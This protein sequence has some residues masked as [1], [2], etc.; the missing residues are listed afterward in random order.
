MPSVVNSMSCVDN[1]T[2][3]AATGGT[4]CQTI[5][6][7]T[8]PSAHDA[9][10]RRMAFWFVAAILALAI[11][12]TTAPS[13]LYRR[14]QAEWHFSSGVLTAVFGVYS[15]AVI[16]SLLLTGSASDGRG[17]KPFILLSVALCVG[18]MV[19]FAVATGVGWLFA[20]RVVQ[21]VGV[22]VGISALGGMLLDLRPGGR[23]SPFV[24]QAAPNIGIVVGA[25]GTGL[26]VD[27]GPKPSVAVYVVL[28][29]AFVALLPVVLAMPETVLVCARKQTA[30]SKIS[31]PAGRKKEFW[32]IALGAISTWAVGG[33]Y[34]SLGPTVSADVLHSSRFVVN[35]LAVALLGA[36]G[37]L[38]ETVFYG[39]SYKS[40]MVIGTVLLGMGVGLVIWSLWPRSAGLFFT[41]SVLLGMGWGLT[42][43]GSFRSLV[44]LAH[45]ARRAEVV[46][47][48][49][50][51]SYLAFS[52]PS[53]AAGYATVAFGL[54][55]TM[56]VFGIAVTSLA[57]I[58]ARTA[59]MINPKPVGAA[60]VEADAAERGA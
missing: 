41:G 21:G 60:K 1:M 45:P 34:L 51:V 24:N 10:R 50:V 3:S 58:A 53:V 11:A 35:A 6:E 2:A 19:L 47:A 9:T 28:L 52:V 44:A 7:A 31:L 48:V 13:I 40:E 5:L 43:V 56:V 57:V 39:W 30:L 32:L 42:A 33:F 36:A 54:R 38:S 18:S 23:Q 49:Y 4:S 25:L 17:R 27:N 12:S 22:G 8:G 15:L 46:A 20:A 16:A 14:Y 29:C 26:L 37:L 59:V 55:G